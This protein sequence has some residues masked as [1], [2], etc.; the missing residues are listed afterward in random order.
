MDSVIRKEP[1]PGDKESSGVGLGEQF[2]RSSF[3]R[4]KSFVADRLSLEKRT[5]HF[6]Y[7]TSLSKNSQETN[8]V[9]TTRYN[10]ISWAPLS[11]LY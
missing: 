7:R 1:D 9:R 5:I 8:Q 4:S 6:G 11:L 3:I 10:L 2:K